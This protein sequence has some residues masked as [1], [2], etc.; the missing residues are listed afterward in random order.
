MNCS[1]CG[2]PLEVT[3]VSAS[4]TTAFER[5]E[6]ADCGGEG[7][8]VNEFDVPGGDVRTSRVVER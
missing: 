1:E 2:G 7:T 6:C 4:E 8:Y 5:Y 3:S